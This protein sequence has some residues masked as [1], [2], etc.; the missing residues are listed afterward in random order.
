MLIEPEINLAVFPLRNS[1]QFYD[2]LMN[3]EQGLFKA[4]GITPMQKLILRFVVVG[5][6]FIILL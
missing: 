2:T 4:S 1:N 3:G 5:I 6:F